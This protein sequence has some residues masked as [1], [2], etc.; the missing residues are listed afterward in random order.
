[1][2]HDQAS[3]RPFPEVPLEDWGARVVEARRARRL[4]QTALAEAAGVTQQTISKVEQGDICPHDRLKMRLAAALDLHPSEL[5]PWP[6][7]I[8]EALRRSG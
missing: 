4:S 6:E 3:T 1:M 2:T 7:S 5:F 8:E